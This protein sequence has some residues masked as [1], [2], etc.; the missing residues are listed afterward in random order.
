MGF[1]P[2]PKPS[3]YAALLSHGKFDPRRAALFDDS[4]RNL[5]PARALGM[6]TV[7]YNDG[8]GQSHWRIDN[9]ALHID[10]ETDHLATFLQSIRI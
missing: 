7:W 9:P 6:T 10:H 1:Q 5:V 8:L 3:A 2:K 4:Q